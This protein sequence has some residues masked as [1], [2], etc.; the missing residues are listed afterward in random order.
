MALDTSP[1]AASANQVSEDGDGPPISSC[2][3]A[4]GFSPLFRAMRSKQPDL[5]KVV[6]AW[7]DRFA[8]DR[9]AAV[10]ELVTLVLVIAD[11]P[12]HQT[13]DKEDVQNRE[14][15]DI[16]QELVAALALEASEKGADFTQHWLISRESGAACIRQNYPSLFRTIS[17]AAPCRM[18]LGGL[19]Q[20]LHGWVLALTECQFRSVR[21]AATIA[22]LHLVEGLGVQCGAL[23]RYCNAALMQ[24]RDVEAQQLGLLGGDGRA[25]VRLTMLKTEQQEAQKFL[26]ELSSVRD[27]LGVALLSRRT[28]DVDP[29][30]RRRCFESLQ[31]W[32]LED[33]ETFLDP[34]W[35][36]YLH[37]G[38]NDRCPKARC[39]SLAVLCELF[40]GDS[41][42][43]TLATQTLAEHVRPRVLARCH[44]IE[45]AVGARAVACATALAG[46][47]L[48]AEEDFDPIIEL[49]W[50]SDGQRRREASAFVSRHVFSE[51]VLDYSPSV[52]G[53]MTT[54]VPLPANSGSAVRRRVQMIL[55]FVGEYADGH[56]QL[57]G[58]LA[59]AFW[60]RTSCLEDWE[61]FAGLALAGGEHSLAGGGHTA[62]V[63]LMEACAQLASEDAEAT[64]GRME[65][66]AYA[67]AVLDRAARALA[68][69][70]EALLS[71]CQ[72]EPLAMHRAAG[73]CRHILRHCASRQR[74]GGGSC[75]GLV[76]GAAGEAVAES[77][78]AAFLRQ[79]DPQALEH[80]AE[81]L[82]YLLELA[83]GTRAVVRDLADTLRHRLLS[84][85]PQ[86]S[87]KGVP[88]G[89]DDDVA[90]VPPADALLAATTRL[91]IL[92]KAFD[93]S[94]C[95]VQ[96]FVAV[97]LELLDS[98]PAAIS[99]GLTPASGPQLAITL[100]ELLTLVLMRHTTAL[101]Q[102]ELLAQ[103]VAHDPINEAELELLPTATNDLCG[104]AA[105]LLKLD[106]NPLVKTAAFATSITLFTAWWNA[107]IFAG[108]GEALAAGGGVVAG[109]AGAQWTV[110][111]RDDLARGLTEHLGRLLLEANAV[112]PGTGGIYGT[113]SPR[114]VSTFSQLFATISRAAV[115]DEVVLP[116]V[117]DPDRVRLAALACALVGACRHIGVAQSPLPALVLSQGL[118]PR[119]DL[120]EAAWCLIRC[121]RK[122]ARLS[123]S[124][125]GRVGGSEAFF[126]MLF[127]AVRAVHQDAG[128]EVARDLSS[129]LL[130]RVV[131]GKLAPMLQAGF[132]LTL[133]AAIELALTPGGARDGL[134][135][136]LLPWVTKHAI[137]DD[138]MRD[139]GLWAEEHARSLGMDGLSEQAGLPA[140]LEACRTTIERGE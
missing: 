94:L 7:L 74:R 98:R 25:S 41:T 32:T 130:N 59:A 83:G 12:S 21:H 82:A 44:D 58:R 19:L 2:F 37:F 108:H 72:A 68:P 31:R 104:V 132:V 102:P 15:E 140:F 128:A 81:S 63:H 65:D 129:R 69:R 56:Y 124:A 73:L 87:A 53:A 5:S 92:A 46:R 101:L 6:H 110:P 51:D 99:Q 135:E 131:V 125:P 61:A 8:E 80:I 122:E 112:P 52:G 76:A 26:H 84:L 50:D 40:R 39:A 96:G 13:I 24:I 54:G 91:R 4:N 57:V 133:R 66:V 16:V 137:E 103:S 43:T 121:L 30:I 49:V 109:R 77:L 95:D 89:A 107:A 47:G 79:P 106:P 117:T 97:A 60:R 71:A 116:V 93:V 88:V 86:V 35:T 36:R 136:A 127:R 33:V 14:P 67:E 70:L 3:L 27:R 85:A 75:D 120:Q 134:L 18:L 123:A 17:T 64:G 105:A 62:L 78:K 138:L 45:P 113:C 115:A 126:A 119:E 9:D 28:K 48:L 100:L 38:L 90:N 34:L 22:G 118:S 42:A 20:V 139:L 29:E 114:S 111:L 55:Q 11:V 1:G 23:R 10:A